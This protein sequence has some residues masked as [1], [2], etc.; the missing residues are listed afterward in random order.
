MFDLSQ[1]MN[2]KVMLLGIGT[3][4]VLVILGLLITEYYKRKTIIKK[5]VS[6]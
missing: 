6:I 3:V 5:K 1:P 2:F 4:I